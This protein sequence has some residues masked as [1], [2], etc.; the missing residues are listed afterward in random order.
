MA[1]PATKR[2]P[3]VVDLKVRYLSHGELK[4][5]HKTIAGFGH[6]MKTIQAISCVLV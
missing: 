4:A 6:G 3:S 2:A 1:A 5:N